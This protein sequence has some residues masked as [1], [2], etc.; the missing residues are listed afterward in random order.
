MTK[1]SP[2]NEKLTV[3]VHGTS[4]FSTIAPD[5]ERKYP[6]NLLIEG[7]QPG[8]ELLDDVSSVSH[9]STIDNDLD[10]VATSQ[11]KQSQGKKRNKVSHINRHVSKNAK[12]TPLRQHFQ[13]KDTSSNQIQTSFVEGLEIN[14]GVKTNK[15]MSP[16]KKQLKIFSKQK[17][18]MMT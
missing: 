9:I 6:F 4:L 16:S 14:D 8:D 11:K 12:T 5:W 17:T 1:S 10:N 7:N 15:K 2:L 18:T 3:I 13:S